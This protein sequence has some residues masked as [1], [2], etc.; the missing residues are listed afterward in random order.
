MLSSEMLFYSSACFAGTQ[1]ALVQYD[2]PVESFRQQRTTAYAAD[3]LLRNNQCCAEVTSEEPEKFRST[4]GSL[5][6]DHS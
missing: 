3:E 5:S 6:I 1:C 4:S 2:D